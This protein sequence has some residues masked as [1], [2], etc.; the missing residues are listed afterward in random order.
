[1]ITIVSGLPRTGTSM[2]MN[3]LKESGIAILTDQTRIADNHNPRGYFEY[4]PAKELPEGNISWLESAEGKAVKVISFYIHH[5]PPK[6]EYKV[7]FME[8]T[9][10]EIVMSQQKIVID[11]NK[12]IHKKEVKMMEDYFKDHIRK[13]KTWIS[14][15]PNFTVHYFSYNNMV[16]NPQ[17]YTSI[18]SEFLECE[19][20][21]SVLTKVIDEKLYTQRVKK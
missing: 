12:R 3:I 10:E 21:G 15:Q 16:A 7:L 11:E 1:M 14:L 5:L 8:R 19:I 20:K 2:M 18:L 9:I 4:Q 13:T 17:E 6:Y